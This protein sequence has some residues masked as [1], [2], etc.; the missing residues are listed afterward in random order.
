MDFFAAQAQAHRKSRWLVLWFILAVTSIIALVYLSSVVVPYV[1]HEPR[2]GAKVLAFGIVPFIIYLL[3]RAWQAEISFSFIMLIVALTLGVFVF[4]MFYH[5]ALTD[6]VAFW[7]SPDRVMQA[8]A[9][10]VCVLVAFS[11]CHA[12]FAADQIVAG[13]VLSF[14]Y[15]VCTVIYFYHDT[16]A[17]TEQGAHAFSLWNSK[18]FLWICLIVGGGIMAASLYKIWQI[19]RHGGALIATQLGGRMIARGTYNTAERR[20]LNVIDEMSIAA[21]IPAPVAFV[22]TDES[23]LNAFAA[24][25]SAQDSVIGVTRGLLESMNRDELQG[26]IA[27]E[28][29]HIVNGDSRLN[30]K[31]IG[32]LYGIYALTLIGRGLMRMRG[33]TAVF[34]VSLCVIGFIGLF[35]GRLIQAAVSREREYLADASAVQFTRHP[36]GLAAAL[37]KLRDSGSGIQ[38]PQAAAAS[39]FFLGAS[40]A[41]ETFWATSSLFATH[42]SLA[43][44]IRRLGDVLLE[45]PD[46][47]EAPAGTPIGMFANSPLPVLAANPHAAMPIVAPA[48]VAVANLPEEI[49]PASLN[50]AQILLA[51]LP[52]T[53]RQ[54]AYCFAGA[55]GILA[56]LLLSRQSDIRAQ[57]EKLLPASVLPVAQ[58]LYQWLGAQ[59]EH[60]ARYRLV[61]LDL[62]LP[63]LREGLDSERQQFIVLAQGLIGADGRVS[64]TEF[65]LYSMLRGALLSPAELR[66][67][68][69]ELRLEQLD[70]DIA[71]LLA[72]LAYA[73][74]ED[75]ETT[76]AAYREAIARSPAGTEYPLPAKAELFLPRISEALSHLALAAPPYRRKLLSACEVAIRHDGKITPVENELLRAFAQSLD[77]PAPLV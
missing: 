18:R 74:H 52:E 1:W 62:I 72:L 63:T 16:A 10:W 12:L 55:S 49:S 69:S 27:H 50:Q 48:A 39:H 2:L 56:G 36:V 13:I 19:A 68:R 14:A 34:G 9:L 7:E 21:G 37:R 20:L 65:A 30:L 22:L 71:V 8:L 67:K 45:P 35:F 3:Y 77:C 75:M 64:P 66:I 58:N 32:T 61:W 25:L 60:G 76:E 40:D 29:S 54:Q 38:H 41:P 43:D 51:H 4:T 44:R 57:Q 59:P 23:S 46:E 6:S 73:G 33:A 53:L 47:A 24:G 11:L 15:I 5:A 31:L 28:I 70:H 26:V 17:G 42:P